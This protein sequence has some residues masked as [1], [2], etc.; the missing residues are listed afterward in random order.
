[1]TALGTETITVRI[2]LGAALT[3]DELVTSHAEH[4]QGLT[5][6]RPNQVAFETSVDDAAWTPR[7]TVTLGQAFQ[8]NLSYERWW[9]KLLLGAP[10]TARYVRAIATRQTGKQFMLWSEFFVRTYPG[11]ETVTVVHSAFGMP[12]V[13]NTVKAAAGCDKRASTCKT[14]FNN[15][16]NFRGFPTIPKPTDTL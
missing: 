12:E 6:F 3:Y 7:G 2:D 4:P 1:M 16:P 15:L 11:T 5:I 13:G 8:P 14:K 9:Y 10:V